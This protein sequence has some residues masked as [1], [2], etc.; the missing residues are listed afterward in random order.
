MYDTSGNIIEDAKL[1]QQEIL[2]PCEYALQKRD[3][4]RKKSN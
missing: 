1:V 3:I 4:L 2:I